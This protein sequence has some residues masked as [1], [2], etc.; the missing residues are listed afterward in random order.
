MRLLLA[1][2]VIAYL[3]GVGVALAPTMREKWTTATASDFAASVASELPYA[4]AWPR[5]A[6]DRLMQQPG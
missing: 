3:V 4:F 2:I 5:R 1:L 6:Y